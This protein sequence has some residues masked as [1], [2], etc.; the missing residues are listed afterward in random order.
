MA[1]TLRPPKAPNLLVAPVEYMQHYQHE[2]NNALR[3][4]FNQIDNAVGVIMEN[5]GGRFISSPHIFASNSSSQ[6][7]T[8][9]NTAT[10]VSWN[11]AID[12]EGFVLNTITGAA[13]AV[14]SGG[15]NIS[16]R[17][18]AENN[19]TSDHT[20]WAWMQI[21]GV[22]VPN[23]TAKFSVPSNASSDSYV[24]CSSF[25]VA[26]LNG[27]SAIK[28]FWATDKAATSGGGLGVFLESYPALTTPFAAPATPSAYGSITFVS[29]LSQ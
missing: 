12:S 24:V 13:E 22:N 23:S 17:L 1:Q 14:Y 25:I 18:Q 2:L 16:Y 9:D 3:L 26:N 15:Y 4:Y 10:A 8:G 27:G 11:A 6:Y 29:E 20:L 7:A 5:S 21:D 28:L 19:D